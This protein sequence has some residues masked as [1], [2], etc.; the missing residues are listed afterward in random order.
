MQ[1]EKKK[2]EEEAAKTKPKEESEDD[3]EYDTEDVSC[4]WLGLGRGHV[5]G[6][7]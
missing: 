7:G 3:D 5:R 4:R 1:E 2:K 6:R